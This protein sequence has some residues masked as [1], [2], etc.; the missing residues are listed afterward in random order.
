MAL[1]DNTQPA[2]TKNDER[3]TLDRALSRTHLTIDETCHVL[4]ISR[5][6]AYRH[7]KA[8]DTFPV[9]KI[10]NVYRVPVIP[11]LRWMGI[12]QADEDALRARLAASISA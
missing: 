3:M 7:A 12:T 2:S 10:G 1:N 9:I 5:P 11:L 6:L 4:N 8:G